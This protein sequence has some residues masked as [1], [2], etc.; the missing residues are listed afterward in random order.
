MLYFMEIPNL[1]WMIWEYP[2]FRKPPNGDFH[3]LIRVSFWMILK[4]TSTHVSSINGGLHRKKTSIF[5]KMNAYFWTSKS[6]MEPT[7]ILHTS[8][9]YWI[10]WGKKGFKYRTPGV[11]PPNAENNLPETQEWQYLPVSKVETSNLPQF[12]WCVFVWP[13]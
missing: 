10:N 9:F 6:F 12:L 2:Y 3:E 5:R 8:S 1:K 11:N 7:W 13:S 4:Q